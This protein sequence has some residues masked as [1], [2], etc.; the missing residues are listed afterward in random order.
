MKIP[1]SDGAPLSDDCRYAES[2]EYARAEGELGSVVFSA[3][4]LQAT[5]RHV[6]SN[7]PTWAPSLERGTS[8]GS[9]WSRSRRS[10]TSMPDQRHR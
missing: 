7:C 6:F 5:R 1:A 9:G 3:F 4:C 10:K 2:H 8:F